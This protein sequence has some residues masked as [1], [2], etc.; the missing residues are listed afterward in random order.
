MAGTTYSEDNSTAAA[1]AVVLRERL[2]DESDIRD[3]LS[4]E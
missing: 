1:A 4:K 3:S 2:F